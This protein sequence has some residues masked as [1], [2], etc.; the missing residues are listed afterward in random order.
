MT[1]AINII[2]GTEIQLIAQTRRKFIP[3][4]TAEMKKNGIANIAVG[5]IFGRRPIVFEMWYQL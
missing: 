3:R 5:A 2:S 1:L 4:P